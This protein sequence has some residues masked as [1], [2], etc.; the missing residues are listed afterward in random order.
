VWQQTPGFLD[1]AR[2]GNAPN[3]PWKSVAQS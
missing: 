3:T 2:Q 1:A